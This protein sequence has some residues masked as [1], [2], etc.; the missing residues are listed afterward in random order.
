[1]E[2]R[3]EKKKVT[4]QGKTSPT[5][6]CLLGSGVPEIFCSSPYVTVPVYSRPEKK[7]LF[8]L[9]GGDLPSSLVLTGDH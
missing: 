8:N 1:M 3:E 6:E 2:I 7:K 9:K 4:M 5:A